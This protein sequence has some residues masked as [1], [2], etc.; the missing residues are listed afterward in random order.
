[1]A[2]AVLI[3]ALRGGAVSVATAGQAAAVP[4]IVVIGVGLLAGAGLFYGCRAVY[5][6]VTA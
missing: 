2:K 3:Q 6:F 4:A 1:M 5:R